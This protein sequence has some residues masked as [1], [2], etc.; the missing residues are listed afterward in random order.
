MWI[1]LTE[2]VLLHV[3]PVCSLKNTT[4]AEREGYMEYNDSKRPKHIS[5]IVTLSMYQLPA[6]CPN[7]YPT[8]H[9]NLNSQLSP[10]PN[11]QPNKSI[12]PGPGFGPHKEQWVLTT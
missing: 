8:T 11:L 12:F 7:P 5:H 1:L 9:P 4:K 3:N 6:L 10:K 2:H